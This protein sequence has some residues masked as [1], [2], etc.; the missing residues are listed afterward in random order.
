MKERIL[1]SCG[2]ENERC[3]RC[4]GSGWYEE[5]DPDR[6]LKV[7]GADY[8]A[9]QTK[10]SRLPKV[11]SKRKKVRPRNQAALDQGPL[12]PGRDP[13][14]LPKR[15]RMA[16]PPGQTQPLPSG[17]YQAQWRVFRLR[18]EGNCFNCR[19]DAKRVLP[20][21]VVSVAGKML[22][23]LLKET[24]VGVLTRS[25][26]LTMRLEDDHLG[27]VVVR[28][29]GGRSTKRVLRVEGLCAALPVEFVASVEASARLPGRKQHKLKGKGR[30]GAPSASSAVT[31]GQETVAS[32]YAEVQD[33]RRIERELD[34]TK[35]YWQLRDHGQ[36]G[37]H[38]THDD[39]D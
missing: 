26:I 21:Q 25:R 9:I 35:D 12:P 32:G 17:P 11:R 14:I 5:R 27:L 36:F 28:E 34:A 31:L 39:Y 8:A 29:Q 10:R 30:S 16:I 3:Y 2:G 18:Y 19:F 1:C 20:A 33:S 23:R 22:A 6:P 38:P 15:P 13:D 7:P 4:G 24:D 37:S